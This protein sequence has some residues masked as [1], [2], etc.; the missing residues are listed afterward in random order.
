MLWFFLW[1]AHLILPKSTTSGFLAFL[2]NF[3]P[4]NVQK[5]QKT[6]SCR[7]G[8]YQMWLFTKITKSWLFD[9]FFL[10]FWAIFGKTTSGSS[11]KCDI[12]N[13]WAVHVW[14]LINKS[15]KTYYNFCYSICCNE[16]IS[17][18]FLLNQLL[19]HTNGLFQLN[20]GHIPYTF[21]H[22]IWREICNSKR[23]LFYHN[24]FQYL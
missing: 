4:K 19:W 20:L 21:Y 8:C 11:P 17:S 7:F 5:C 14:Y 16:P 23:F 12:F 13:L 9:C 10:R 22:H 3:W 24:D 15:Y 18:S 2:S 6:G 1:N